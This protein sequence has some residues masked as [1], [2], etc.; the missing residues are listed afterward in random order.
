MGRIV[1]K[2]V[3]VDNSEQAD[4]AVL[5]TMEPDTDPPIFLVRAP[6]GRRRDSLDIGARGLA[7][8]FAEIQQQTGFIVRPQDVLTVDESV[9][10]YVILPLRRVTK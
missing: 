2:E 10:E 8:A 5:L 3:R 6:G 4:K 1:F 7:K 9:G